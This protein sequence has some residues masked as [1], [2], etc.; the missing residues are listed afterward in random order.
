MF[1]TF[2]FFVT[3]WFFISCDKNNAIVTCVSYRVR[4]CR[5]MLILEVP[6]L[7]NMWFSLQSKSLMMVE[8]IAETCRN[9]D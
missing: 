7:M 1:G 4:K 2:D 6:V 5:V 3:L 9:T 8:A